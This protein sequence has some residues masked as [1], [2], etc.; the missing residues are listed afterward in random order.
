M[1]TSSIEWT[2]EDI[3]AEREGAALLRLERRTGATVIEPTMRVR[4]VRYGRADARTAFDRLFAGGKPDRELLD[5]WADLKRRAANA[6]QR[7]DDR[8]FAVTLRGL[9]PAEIRKALFARRQAS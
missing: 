9:P 2:R 4:Q 7:E 6:L 1:N 3:E 8:R 5:T